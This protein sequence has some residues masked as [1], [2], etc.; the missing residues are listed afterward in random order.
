MHKNFSTLI[1][2][3][4]MYKNETTSI[5]VIYTGGTIG[6]KHNP[7]TG[8]LAPFNFGQIEVEV[9]ELHCDYVQ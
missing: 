6:M 8:S 9:P 2:S 3:I 4:T 1:R 5:L 7:E